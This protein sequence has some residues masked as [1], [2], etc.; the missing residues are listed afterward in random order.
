MNIVFY[1]SDHGFGHVVRNIPVIASLITRYDAHIYIV[2]G[3]SQL[4]FAKD[5]LVTMLD[6]KQ[7]E[8]IICREN[9][10][11]IG[12]IL[13]DGTLDVDV[14]QLTAACSR[15]LAELPDRS[16]EEAEWLKNN[17]IDAALCDMPVWSIKACNL[18]HV[19]MLYVGN[20]TWVELYRE[21]LPDIIS[22]TFESYYKMIRHALIFQFHTDEMRRIIENADVHETGLVSRPFHESDV[23][24]I[25]NGINIPV[26]F[27]SIGMS[28]H[29][30]N[31]IDVSDINAFFITTKGIP[32]VGNNVICIDRD[33]I[34]TQDYIKAA[35]YIISKAG[36]GTVAEAVLAGKPM[37]LFKRD[38]VLEDRNT[39][40]QLCDKGMAISIT[41]NDL[42]N[43]EAI[44]DRLKHLSS[45]CFNDYY[46]ASDEIADTLIGLIS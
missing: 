39:V 30:N 24:K 6:R 16:Y 8:K 32:V 40:K 2:C 7:Y 43:M 36:W 33:T 10:T 45:D 25:K 37:A 44:I 38:G 28:A 46:D 19:P 1:L 11:D 18:A 17:N 27:I 5:V 21:F 12:L 4:G 35:D 14:E 26:V 42:Y 20:F 13:H 9:H 3:R 23:E 31:V 41:E 29:F 22:D 34:N 15:Y